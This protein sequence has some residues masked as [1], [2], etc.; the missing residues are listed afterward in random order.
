[1]WNS[2]A[3]ERECQLIRSCTGLARQ[4]AVLSEDRNLKWASQW[5]GGP[6]LLEQYVRDYALCCSI[7]R[8]KWAPTEQD[9]AAT[10]N[11]FYWSFESVRKEQ[12]WYKLESI[13]W[14]SCFWSSQAHFLG[15]FTGCHVGNK[16]QFTF[17]EENTLENYSFMS[18]N[19]VLQGPG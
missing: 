11:K 18:K 14:Y 6:L 16:G 19:Q 1:M 2:H 15:A 4:A 17:P 13:L 3:G 5:G 7:S 12:W 10:F 8:I 9:H